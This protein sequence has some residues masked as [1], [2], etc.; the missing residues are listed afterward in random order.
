MCVG[1]PTTSK[2]VQIVIMVSLH[3]D[4]RTKTKKCEFVILCHDL[5][6]H[7]FTQNHKNT[8]YRIPKNLDQNTNVYRLD[9]KSNMQLLLSRQI[10]SK[11][12]W[13]FAKICKNTEQWFIL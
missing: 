3:I 8:N 1:L 11:I 4:E 6:F 9:L 13:H 10:V 5:T 7:D 12:W 2:T